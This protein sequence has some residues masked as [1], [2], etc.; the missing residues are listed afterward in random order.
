MENF[1]DYFQLCYDI[2]STE[3]PDTGCV[4]ARDFNPCSNGFDAKYLTKYC[5][6]NLKQVV[7]IRKAKEN[8]YIS[9]IQP[10]RD[11]NPCVWWKKIWGLTGKNRTPVVLVTLKQTWQ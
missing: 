9:N 10:H 3:S 1:Y 2:L 7:K 5:D 6:V 8:Y 11:C 4:A